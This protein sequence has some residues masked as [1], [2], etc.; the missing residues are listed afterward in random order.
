[1]N[2]KVL[3]KL[4]VFFSKYPLKKFKKGE[5]ILRPGKMSE[6]VGFIKTGYVRLY[7]TKDTGQEI[8]MQ[9][10]KPTLYLTTIYAL[11]GRENRF[12]FEA[13]TPVEMREAPN[14]DML[15]FLKANPEVGRELM[16]SVMAAFLDLITNTAN[17][18]AGNAYNR[19][20]L[21]VC[22]LTNKTEEVNFGIT[23]KLIA[24][25]TG[26]TRETVTLQMIKLEKE[27]IILNKSK[28]IQVLDKDKLIAAA[29]ME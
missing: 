21:M 19:V 1:M 27:G 15:D 28:S 22:S 25:L 17:L 29:K 13:I 3:T 2:E 14:Q 18:L 16:D 5:V 23:H 26:L 24:S 4:D 9:F 11:T 7:S 20:A 6:K 12:S 8:T 10:F